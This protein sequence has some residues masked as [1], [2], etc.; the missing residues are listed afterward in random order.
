M[1]FTPRAIGVSEQRTESGERRSAGLSRAGRRF[2]RWSD[3]LE[4]RNW[5]LRRRL[6]D[7]K[8]SDRRQDEDGEGRRAGR[9]RRCRESQRV[10]RGP[11]RRVMVIFVVMVASIV[12]VVMKAGISDRSH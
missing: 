5:R 11:V 12:A 8:R 4:D 6:I 1:G 10:V 2:A 3:A 9:F 7:E